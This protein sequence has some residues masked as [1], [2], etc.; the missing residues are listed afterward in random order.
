MPTPATRK[1]RWG[2]SV[3]RNYDKYCGFK[4]GD[5]NIPTMA[6]GSRWGKSIALYG[7]KKNDDERLLQ[8]YVMDLAVV[9]AASANFPAFF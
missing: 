8:A 7:S 6:Q 2:R 5:E 1:L 3:S 9:H 4:R